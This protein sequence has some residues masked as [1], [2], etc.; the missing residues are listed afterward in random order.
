MGSSFHFCIPNPGI[1]PSIQHC[2]VNAMS[3]TMSIITGA[4]HKESNF[5]SSV[6]MQKLHHVISVKSH[7][8][9]PGLSH[10][11]SSHDGNTP[12]KGGFRDAMK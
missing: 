3:I 6:H 4:T 9:G 8:S 2:S 7:L 1:I 12:L 5:Y 11:Q 10:M